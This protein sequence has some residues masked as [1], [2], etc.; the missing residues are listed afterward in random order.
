MLNGLANPKQPFQVLEGALSNYIERP[1]NCLFQFPT[2]PAQRERMIEPRHDLTVLRGHQN[3]V[4][5][6]GV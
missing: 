5:A 6:G 1:E 3:T 4:E 2:L